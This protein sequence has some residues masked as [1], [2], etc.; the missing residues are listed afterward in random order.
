MARTFAGTTSVANYVDVGDVTAAR[1]LHADAWSALAFFYPTTLGGDQR[2]IMGKDDAG[3]TG[4]L[5]VRLGSGSPFGVEVR[6]AGALKLTTGSTVLT[7]DTWYLLILTHSTSGDG[8]DLRAWV[9]DMDGAIVQSGSGT[10]SGDATFLTGVVNV[11][12]RIN[13]LNDPFLGK[14]AHWCY[15]QADLSI[16]GTATAEMFAY[17]R[18]PGRMARFW[19]Q[20][21]GVPFYLPLGQDSPEPDW[22]GSGNNGTLTGT[23]AVSSDPPIL[24]YSHWLAQAT[25]PTAPAAAPDTFKQ[26]LSWMGDGI[27]LSPEEQIRVMAY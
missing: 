4:Q 17:V 23:D 5:R 6:H 14:I 22:S 21:Y 11:G 12:Q 26:D 19:K 7:V 13:A 24:P 16:D 3:S 1:F 9:L 15:V 2:N 20:E 10:T 8:G 27:H 18:D 25:M